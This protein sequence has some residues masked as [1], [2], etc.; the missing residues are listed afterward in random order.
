MLFSSTI[1]ACGLHIWCVTWS[2][3]PTW[4]AISIAAGLSSSVLNHSKALGQSGRTIDRIV[5]RSAYL[6][7]IYAVC[8]QPSCMEKRLFDGILLGLSG[9]SYIVSKAFDDECTRLEWHALS[10][11]LATLSHISMSSIAPNQIP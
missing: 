3:L 4:H 5:V 2:A 9:L 11:L 8:V 7:D 1:L 10:H 6:V